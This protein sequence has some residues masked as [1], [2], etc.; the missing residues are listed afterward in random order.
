MPCPPAQDDKPEVQQ[1]KKRKLLSK[2]DTAALGRAPNP[3]ASAKAPSNA[4]PKQN[5]ARNP[6][7][8]ATS[9]AGA[10]GRKQTVSMVCPSHVPHLT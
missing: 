5:S 1:T 10:K 8:R 7:S 3:S 4:A 6:K 9:S 2:A